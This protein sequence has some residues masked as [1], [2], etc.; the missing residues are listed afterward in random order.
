MRFLTRSLAG[1]LLF[2]LTLGLLAVG[3]ATLKSAIEISLAPPDPG[4]PAAERSFSARV[5]RLEPGQIA[6]VLTLYGEIA[7]RRTLELRAAAAGQI[8]ELA[9]GFAD[10]A[11]VSAGQLLVRVDP[12]DAQSARDLA[13]AGLRDAEVELR[14]ATRSLE[15]ARADLAVAQ[16]QVALRQGAYDRQKGIG[17]RGFGTATDLE[18]AELALSAARQALVSRRQ[19][20]AQAEAR[21]D[22]AGTAIER[23]KLA[24]ADAE[25]RLAETELRAGFDG[26][27]SGVTAVAGGLVAKAE[28]LGELV[29]PDDLEVSFRVSTAKFAS[30]VDA[31]GHLMPLGVTAALDVAGAEISAEGR[32]ARVDA[33]V[34][35]GLSG[36]L[37]FAS[38]N[39]PRGLKPGDFVTVRVQTRPLDG[40][41]LLP[42]AAI[43]P[44]GTLLVVGEGDRL[45]AVRAEVV[46][47]EGDAV[48]IR[49][50]ALAGREVVT[51]RSPLLGAGILIRPIRDGAQSGEAAEDETKAA[52]IDLTPERRAELIALVEGNDRLPKDARERILVQLR[53]GRV[54]AEM[55]QRIEARMGG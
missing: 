33:T 1:L 52:L 31:E 32:L 8:V 22:K 6:P 48:M 21:V 5:A 2:A 34:G 41:A 46:H 54:P 3:L 47:H 29:D 19:A 27:L 11:R 55:V 39:A 13:Q 10:G 30:L 40:V 23:Q 43:G 36:R 20:V 14:D 12:A 4:R 15:L 16:E 53:E 18:T 17:N 50:G 35:A 7:S 45:E 49:V 24:L 9:A 26:V 51:E 44:D 38:L 37:V 28:K 25:R 42:A